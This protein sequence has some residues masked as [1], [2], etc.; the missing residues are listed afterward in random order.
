[1]RQFRVFPGRSVE[2]AA[3]ERRK[4][5]NLVGCVF[6]AFGGPEGMAG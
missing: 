5:S 2:D 4:H 1:M 3:N 6:I